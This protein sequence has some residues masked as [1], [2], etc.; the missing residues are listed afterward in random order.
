MNVTNDHRKTILGFHNFLTRTESLYKVQVSYGLV[1]C[2]IARSPWK[3][4]KVLSNLNNLEKQ[5]LVSQR[6]PHRH[7]AIVPVR[8]SGSRR[9][10]I[11]GHSTRGMS[12]FFGL[13]P[14]APSPALGWL[15]VDW[16]GCE[17]VADVL[18]PFPRFVCSVTLSNCL[19]IRFGTGFH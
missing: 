13:S 1:E 3:V 15:H 7:A 9:Y 10:P 2:V 12:M 16:C 11:V 8:S 14:P 6:C 5:L 4:V 17:L 19:D 18:A